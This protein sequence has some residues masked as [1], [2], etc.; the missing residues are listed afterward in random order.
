MGA[1][2][3]YDVNKENTT[4]ICLSR[5]NGGWGW[6]GQ[7]R[8]R[9]KR[10]FLL[11]K[12]LFW[13]QN[14]FDGKPT[15]YMRI[16]QY[17]YE[18]PSNTL[19][20]QQCCVHNGISD[21]LTRQLSCRLHYRAILGSPCFHWGAAQLLQHELGLFLSHSYSKRTFRGENVR[22]DCHFQQQRILVRQWDLARPLKTT[23]LSL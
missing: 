4:R 17:L 12:S 1:K 13:K 22:Q 8:E 3:T 10:N 11:E 7:E 9:E 18:T 14:Q 2:I 23:M 15:F 16:I 19:H 5:P 21:T 20:Y 6:G